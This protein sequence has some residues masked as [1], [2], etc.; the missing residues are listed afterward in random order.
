[1]LA[2]T[3]ERELELQHHKTIPTVP[4]V[5]CV[6]IAEWLAVLLLSL[7]ICVPINR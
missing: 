1:M 6:H 3:R 2:A 7:V 4:T 5:G